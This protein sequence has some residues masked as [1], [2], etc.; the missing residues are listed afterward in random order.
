MNKEIRAWLIL[1]AWVLIG[2]SPVMYAASQ[3][4]QE[5]EQ[6]EVT[7]KPLDIYSTEDAIEVQPE[8]FYDVPLGEELQL[9]IFEECEKHNI[10]PAIIIAMIERESDFDASAVGD[11]GKSLGLM[12]IQPR[13][14]QEKMDELGCDDLLDPYQNITVGVAIVS[15]LK[16]KDSDLYWVLMAYNGGEAYATRKINAE[17]YS[18]YAVAIVERASELEA[19]YATN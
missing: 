16:D 5:V 12:Q 13:W 7:V 10:A 9:H 8:Q 19:E 14:H 11:K 17:D 18:D 2:T 4:E 3:R 15:E 1:I 6:T